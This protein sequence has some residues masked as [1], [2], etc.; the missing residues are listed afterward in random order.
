MAEYEKEIKPEC[1]HHMMERSEEKRE[2][3]CSI[4][5]QERSMRGSKTKCKPEIW[6]NGDGSERQYEKNPERLKPELSN[7]SVSSQATFSSKNSELVWTPVKLK[8]KHSKE[9]ISKTTLLKLADE[10][11]DM[12]DMV[13]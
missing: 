13:S 2:M 7:E 8:P 1:H 4:E 11:S 3:I 6:V 12:S 9:D 10:L 5:R